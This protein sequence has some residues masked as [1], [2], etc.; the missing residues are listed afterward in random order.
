MTLPTKAPGVS[1]SLLQIQNEFGGSSTNGISLSEYYAGGL[2]VSPGTVGYP[3]GGTTFVTIPSSGAI[4]IENFFGAAALIPESLFSFFSSQTWTVPNGVS[5]IKMLVIAGGGGGGTGYNGVTYQEAGGGGGAGGGILTSSLPVT[6]GDIISMTI[7]AGGAGG[8]GPVGSQGTNGQ[9]TAVVVPPVSGAVVPVSRYFTAIGGGYGGMYANGNSYETQQFGGNGGSGGGAN[10]AWA[11]DHFGGNV[12]G[13][14]TVGQGHDGSVGNRGSWSGS[15]GGYG[16]AAS[17]TH[18]GI[19]ATITLH[20]TPIT[21]GGGGGGAGSTGQAASE[22]GGAGGGTGVAG[23]SGSAFTGGGGG[24]GG[25]FVM[26]TVFTE[27]IIGVDTYLSH[28]PNSGVLIMA[29]TNMGSGQVD[30]TL[31]TVTGNLLTFPAFDAFS[32]STL[33]AYYSSNDAPDILPAGG[34]G[35]SGAVYIL[36]NPV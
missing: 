19:G 28:V 20:T 14:G 15:G 6:P 31:Y 4:S 25:T 11:G 1:L 10:S 26:A 12:P 16:A 7:G 23:T 24:G 27:Q 8:A 13:Q 22:G 2:Y 35:G 9:D 36:V 29:G 21:F 30:P 18:G 17:N 32:S 34:N 3:Y 5:S 33:I